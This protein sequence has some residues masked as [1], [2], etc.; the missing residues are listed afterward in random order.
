MSEVTAWLA[1]LVFIFI[2]FTPTIEAFERKH[3]NAGA[4]FILN[5]FC[6][7]TFFGWVLALVWANTDNIKKEIK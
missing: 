3:N 7:W 4:I 5:L 6:G 1:V 2:Y